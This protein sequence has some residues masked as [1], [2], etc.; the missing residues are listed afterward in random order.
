MIGDEAN[1][2]LLVSIKPKPKEKRQ[3]FSSAQDNEALSRSDER[4]RDFVHDAKTRQKVSDHS[5]SVS[6]SFS[7]IRN[8]FWLNR[9]F[10][11]YTANVA[12]IVGI[13][14]F[15]KGST[16]EQV[17]TLA[18]VS[19][20]LFLFGIVTSKY[21]HRLLQR[22]VEAKQV[23]LFESAIGEEL[24]NRRLELLDKGASETDINYVASGKR[25]SI[26]NKYYKRKLSEFLIEERKRSLCSFVAYS[27]FVLGLANP[28]IVVS[29]GPLVP[30]DLP[31]VPLFLDQM[32]L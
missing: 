7:G 2:G 27:F 31:G 23:L 30:I 4:D 16:S 5:F 22:V 6:L 20:V 8:S 32:K 24:L 18:L 19:A 14:T 10:G 12:G 21:E 17:F 28:I 1:E 9:I 25:R 29:F 15:I 3:E 13:A 11:P 26:H